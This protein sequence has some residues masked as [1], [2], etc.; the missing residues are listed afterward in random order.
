MQNGVESTVGGG[1]SPEVETEIL[2]KMEAGGCGGFFH[3]ELGKMDLNAAVYL[4]SIFL[5]ND[6]VLGMGRG[7]IL[8][9]QSPVE[10][11]SRHRWFS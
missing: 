1:D 6:F 10:A 2:I 8:V 11:E 9:G 7:G 3:Q 4:K 5:K